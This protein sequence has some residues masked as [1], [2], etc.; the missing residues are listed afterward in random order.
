MTEGRLADLVERAFD[1]RGYV[2]LR[3]NDGSEVVGYVYDRGP[4]HVEVF[5]ESATQRL[6]I[7]LADI[8][9]IAFSGDDAAARALAMWERRKGRLESRD[10]PAWGDWHEAGPV[11]FVVALDA[12]LRPVARAF[13]ATIRGDRFRARA[14]GSEIVA[15]AVGMGGGSR[16][17]V[18]D[19]RPRL[20]VSCGFSGALDGALAAGDLVLATAVRDENGEVIAAP[21]AQRAAAAA[22]LRG[23]RCFEGDLACATSV[24]ASAEEKRALS[25]PG[26]LAVDMESHPAARAATDAGIPWLGL[27]VIVDPLDVSM[28]QFTR[29]PHQSYVVPAL[30]YALNGPRAVFE[31]VQLGARSKRA[32]S[33]LEIAVRRVLPALASVE[34]RA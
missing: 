4:S 2:T 24:A 15:R 26:T 22:A 14:A 7:P 28:P 17:V 20:V 27:R 6:R 8:A 29:G 11:L 13:G 18:E 12:E 31:L 3:R 19:E 25:R 5:D 34:A 32:A 16:K 10:T 30:R 23:L 1:Y 9:D 21:G 33:A